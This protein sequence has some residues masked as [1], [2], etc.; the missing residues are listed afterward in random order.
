MELLERNDK[1]DC[2]RQFSDKLADLEPVLINS[3]TLQNLTETIASLLSTLLPL[4][5]LAVVRF[6]SPQNPWNLEAEQ[7]HP[8]PFFELLLKEPLGEVVAEFSAG[9]P[10]SDSQLEQ[11]LAGAGSTPPMPYTALPLRYEA[12]LVGLALFGKSQ[13]QGS[14]TEKEKPILKA[15]AAVMGIS[16]AAKNFDKAQ[17]LYRLV[18]NSTMDCMSANL[19]VTDLHTDKILFMNRSM[20]EKFGIEHPE[21]QVCWKVL[22]RG[23]KGRCPFCPI[24]QL[25]KDG[26]SPS[27]SWEEHNT[28]NGR[29]YEN[30]DTLIRWIDGS[31]VHLQQSVDITDAHELSKAASI[32]DLTGLLN[33][34]AGKQH[35]ENTLRQASLEG[36]TVTV[37]L[38]DINL[39]KE[40]N[41]TYGHAE[42]DRMLQ[43]I[44]DSVKQ[45]LD[46]QSYMFRLN[47]DEFIIVFYSTAKEDAACAIKEVE[48]ELTQRQ[49]QLRLPYLLEFCCGLLEI[50]PDG[51]T[52]LSEILVRV[53]EAMYEQ[54]RR[55]HVERSER[56]FA[57]QPLEGD[58]ADFEYDKEHLYEAIAGSTDDY[59]YVC[60]MKTGTFRYPKAM[61][62][63]FNLPGEVVHNAAAFWSSLIHEED[64][65][66]F[67]EAN[68][69][70]ADGR[71]ES[72]SIEYRAKNRRGEWVWLRCRGHLK[73]DQAG[74]PSIFAGIITNLGKKNTIDHMTGLLNKFG[75][76]NEISGLIKDRPDQPFGI[77]ILGIDEF[78]H[79]ND[80][81]DRVFGDEVIR[82]ISQKIQG[83]LPS[84]ATIYRMDG[85]EFAIL[86]RDGTHADLQRIYSLIHE[87]FNHRQEYNGKKYYCTLSA[88]SAFYPQDAQTHLGLLKHA[89]YSLEY[90]KSCG[91]NCMTFFS[92]DILTHREKSLELI[93]LLRESIDNNFAGFELF[94]QP[95]VS[96]DS[97]RVVGAEALARWRC[98][99]Y[100][101]ISPLEFIPL[102][103][104]SGLI[105]PVGKWIFK[106]AVAKCSEWVATHP[107]F[108]M[109]I[110]LSYLQVREQD[111]I[112]FMKQVLDEAQLKPSNI[113]VEL[114][115]SY[116]VKE[117]G[118]VRTIFDDIRRLG[119][120]IAMDDFGTGYS[121]LGILKSSPADIVKIDKTFI[122]D[123]RNSN[124]DATF[125]RFVVE[126]CHDVEISVCLEGVETEEEYRIVS[127]MHLDYIQGYL[128][129]RPVPAEEFTQK[130][131]L[132]NLSK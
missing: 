65:Q 113:V 130:Y 127:P 108:V 73:R 16:L 110:N 66:A 61:V 22:Q 44:A 12:S 91:K 78:K 48:A 31:T 19:Y 59:V 123:I 69:E 11:I 81:Y 50:P 74:E 46:Q 82:I 85:D 68:Q 90:A 52:P 28:V 100:G 70:I 25:E 5:D 106:E 60:N 132:S 34:R 56:A 30:H 94:Y 93:E 122:K 83:M 95:Q 57:D 42:G 8:H 75:F 88:G 39:L 32:D 77:M 10:V 43:L 6:R 51:Q 105:I 72:H 4:G 102:L 49:V 126:L 55:F 3:N 118:L 23:M 114:T 33:R 14:W 29:I 124:F 116:L 112:P 21:G 96:A 38:Y 47:G 92:S 87:H 40:V 9:H 2:L 27:Y 18:F 24:G 103:E 117:S 119:L 58:S 97:G 109:S 121:S 115:E 104:E 36:Q 17:E 98:E 128:F 79:I 89:G 7:L 15:A 26:A 71:V 111:F 54:K 80:L 1:T 120:K 76:K 63:E 41:D 64:K 99:K 53:D 101:A 45:K 129:G 67:M 37:G 86:V 125:I 131:F 107:A 84:Y 20:K 62:E 13:Q 35:L